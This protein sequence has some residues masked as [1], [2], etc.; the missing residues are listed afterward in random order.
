MVKG[1]IAFW[2]I[3]RIFKLRGLDIF[4]SKLNAWFRSTIQGRKMTPLKSFLEQGT[5]TPI[6]AYHPALSSTA[7]RCVPRNF[8]IQGWTIQCMMLSSQSNK[9]LFLLETGVLKKFTNVI[10]L[11]KKDCYE[12]K[13]SLGK[14]LSVHINLLICKYGI[15]NSILR[16]RETVLH[17][18]QSLIGTRNT[19]IAF[20]LFNG[21]NP[22]TLLKW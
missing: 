3:H 21:T 7:V 18:E 6:T 1:H 12:G 17:V 2:G 20:Q 16:T 4:Q 14:K 13:P 11:Y 8:S 19:L 22:I 15:Q 10:L 5:R 9:I